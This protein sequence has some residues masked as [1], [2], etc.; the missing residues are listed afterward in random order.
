M[1]IRGTRYGRTPLQL[2]LEPGD[3][4][5]TLVNRAALFRTTAKVR[6]KPGDRKS[7]PVN[8]GQGSLALTIT[9]FALIRV[10]GEPVADIAVSF[11]ELA[12]YEGRYTIDLQVP[13]TKVKRQ[14]TV[15]IRSG[16]RLTEA[17]DLREQ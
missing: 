17:L 12:L 16:E 7:L 1:L 6:L 14:L 2:E 4:V 3:H 5:V 8:P 13:D 15:T 10:N 11:K 9:P